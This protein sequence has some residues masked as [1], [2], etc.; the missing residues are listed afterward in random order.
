VG[1]VVLVERVLWRDFPFEKAARFFP[2]VWAT[3]EQT[4]LIF[5]ILFDFPYA[6]V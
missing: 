3:E 6:T 2:F 1:K 5:S 4:A